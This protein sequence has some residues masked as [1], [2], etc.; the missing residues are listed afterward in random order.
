MVPNVTLAVDGSER[1]SCAR[2]YS[3]KGNDLSR[4]ITD[5]NIHERVGY[6]IKHAVDG[7]ER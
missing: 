4:F 7:L 3:A 5:D 1:Y 6:W 2:I